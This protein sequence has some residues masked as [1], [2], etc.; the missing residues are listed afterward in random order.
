MQFTIFTQTF[1][2]K[3]TFYVTFY[4]YK[5]YKV[6]VMMA[7]TLYYLAPALSNL[8]FCSNLEHVWDVNRL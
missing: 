3:L 6:N 7:Y 4:L 1:T 5:V 2:Q 8:Q